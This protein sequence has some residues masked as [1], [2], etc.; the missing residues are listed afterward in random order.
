MGVDEEEAPRRPCAEAEASAVEVARGG[1]VVTQGALRAWCSGRGYRSHTLLTARPEELRACLGDVA[2]VAACEERRSSVG[3]ASGEQS[4]GGVTAAWHVQA[5][6]WRGP[7]RAVVAVV[8]EYRAV[9]VQRGV[10]MLRA[11]AHGGILAVG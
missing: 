3:A 8:R 6:R 1:E 11:K 2:A 4:G 9:R 10:E 7:R 5:R